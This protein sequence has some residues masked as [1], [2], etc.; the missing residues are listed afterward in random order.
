MLF[1]KCHCT[2]LLVGLILC[3]S[4]QY[5]TLPESVFAAVESQ[6]V[7][8]SRLSCLCL[9]WCWR[10]DQGLHAVDLVQG[11]LLTSFVV[12]PEIQYKFPVRKLPLAKHFRNMTNFWK[13]QKNFPRIL[14]LDPEGGGLVQGC[15]LVCKTARE[16]GEQAASGLV[17]DLDLDI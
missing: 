10:R 13:S 4:V 12:R 2:G 6:Q 3:Q 9:W 8:K 15:L 7:A 1:S 16:E 14:N 11:C 17:L 5:D